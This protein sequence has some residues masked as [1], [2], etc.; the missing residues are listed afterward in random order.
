MENNFYSAEKIVK[1][2]YLYYILKI[3]FFKNKIK[4]YD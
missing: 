4:R 1:I 2:E 3:P